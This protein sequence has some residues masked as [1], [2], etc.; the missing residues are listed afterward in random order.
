MSD[1]RPR[2]EQ[3]SC[4][5]SFVAT[6]AGLKDWSGLTIRELER[7]A[8]AAGDRLPRSTLTAA[9]SRSTLP[10]QELV[11]AF[12]RACGGDEEEIAEWVSARRRIATGDPVQS[13]PKEPVEPR[14]RHVV[15]A[16]AVFGL[17]TGVV[18]GRV[19]RT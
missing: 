6:M 8:E 19:L 17:V 3:A 12:V 5:A 9:L 15:L 11:E 4:A 2:P 1:V 14:R 10:R 7:R 16:A 13:R 18:L